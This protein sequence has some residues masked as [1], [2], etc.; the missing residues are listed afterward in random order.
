MPDVPPAVALRVPVLTP[1]EQHARRPPFHLRNYFRQRHRLFHRFSE[2]IALDDESWYSVTPEKIAAHHA[3][4]LTALSPPGGD[5]VIVDAFCGCGG[6]AIQFAHYASQVVAIDSNAPRLELAKHNASV[7]GVGEHI[8]F[9]AGDVHDVLPAL[10]SSS[11]DAVFMSPPWGGPS[12]KD[13]PDFDVRPF[14]ELVELA[15][16]LTPNIAILVPRNVTESAVEK[17]F[18]ACEVEWNSLGGVLKTTTLYFGDLVGLGCDDEDDD[19]DD[20]DEKHK[21]IN[22]VGDSGRG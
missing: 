5:S 20:E 10:R 6:N 7:Y 3:R 2:G 18:G 14:V 11:V 1:A 17:Y 19:N 13:T 15:R 8:D 21:K 22:N 16:R 12:Y 9:L 4:R